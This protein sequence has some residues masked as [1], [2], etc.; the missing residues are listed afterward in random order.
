MPTAI[1]IVGGV[2]RAM[3]AAAAAGAGGAVM[4]KTVLAGSSITAAD[5]VRQPLSTG[6]AERPLTYLPFVS[7]LSLPGL[8]SFVL[9]MKWAT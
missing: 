1:T 2:G 4:A 7:G 5:W 9:V 3:S 6:P 8:I